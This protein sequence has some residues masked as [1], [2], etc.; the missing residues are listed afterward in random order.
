MSSIY[1]SCDAFHKA[2]FGAVRAG[3][4]VTFTLRVPAEFGCTAP[5][6][7]LHRDGKAPAPFVLHSA[8]G[9]DGRDL[10]TITLPMPQ[11]G[12]YFYYFD[13]YT[14]YR[15]LYRGA[16]GEAYVTTGTGEE[17]QLTVYE[18]GFATPQAIKGGVMYQIFPDRFFEGRPKPMPFADR[19]Y[20]E[21]KSG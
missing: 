19:I 17:Y 5:R 20:R 6:L 4:A 16:L 15:K 8:G 3:Q 13:L 1:N 21:N 18:A 2:P 10:F 7:V 9:A 14:G 11:P 12:L